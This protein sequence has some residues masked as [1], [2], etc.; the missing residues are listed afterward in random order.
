MRRLKQ[1][2]SLVL[3]LIMI[4]S[5]LTACG[6]TN[7]TESDEVEEV[8]IAQINLTPDIEFIAQ[9][10]KDFKVSFAVENGELADDISADDIYLTSS[11]KGMSA[12]VVSHSG[13]NLTLQLKGDIVPNEANAYQ[14]GTVN[15]KASAFKDGE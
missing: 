2:L 13:N 3:A 6:E 10:S 5:V 11:F 7:G 4:G 14:W 1:T 12:E 8:E 9:A 15:V